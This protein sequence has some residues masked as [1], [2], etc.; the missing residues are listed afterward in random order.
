M[1]LWKPYSQP[2]KKPPILRTPSLGHCN[3]AR[4]FTHYFPRTILIILS[5]HLRL[6]SQ[7]FFSAE[8]LTKPLYALYISPMHATFPIYLSI[9]LKRYLVYKAWRKIFLNAGCRW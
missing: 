9:Y 3:T 2:F 7:T 4:I 5:Y 8:V 1:K 6:D